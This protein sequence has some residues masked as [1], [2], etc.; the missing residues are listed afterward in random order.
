MLSN[1]NKRIQKLKINYIFF[2]K[3]KQTFGKFDNNM[4]S[5]E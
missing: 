1:K 2:H 3:Y 5:E 4:C